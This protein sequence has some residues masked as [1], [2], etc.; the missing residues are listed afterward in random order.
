MHPP[1]QLPD[2]TGHLR[3]RIGIRLFDGQLQQNARFLQIFF[4]GVKRVDPLA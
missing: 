4:Q 1:A 2:L 3:H